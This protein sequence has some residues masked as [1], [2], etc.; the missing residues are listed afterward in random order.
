MSNTNLDV[1]NHF[2][3]NYICKRVAVTSNGTMFTASS[4]DGHKIYSY[5]NH[6]MIARWYKIESDIWAAKAR[7]KWLLLVNSD[8]YSATTAIHKALVRAR[9]TVHAP[10]APQI[11]VPYPDAQ[12]AAQHAVN[13]EYLQNQV[14]AIALKLKRS[15]TRRD[16]YEIEHEHATEQAVLYYNV[17]NVGKEVDK[18]AQA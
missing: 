1:A 15:R 3:K 17:F 8:R 4:D 14:R 16:L 7:S 11:E 18:D 6:Y 9:C 2:A 13:Y 12:T 10:R 5:G